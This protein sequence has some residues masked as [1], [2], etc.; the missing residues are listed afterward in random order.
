MDSQSLLRRL[1]TDIAE[2]DLIRPDERIVLGVSGGP[3]SMAMMHAL[4]E[5]NGQDKLHWSLHVAHLNHRIRGAE[6]EADAEFVA[7]E[8]KRLGLDRTIESE[9]I[10]ALSASSKRSIE[11]TARDRRYAFFNRVCIRTGS[12]VVAVAH[13]ADDN[14]ETVLHHIIRGSG[15]RGLAGIPASRVMAP[16]SETRIVRPM[17]RFRR[18]ELLAYLVQEDIGYRRDETN[19]SAVYTRN[20]LRNRVLPMLAEEFNPRIHEALLRL[21]EQARW[22]ADYLRESAARHFESVVLDDGEGQL[23]LSVESLR[24]KKPIIQAE[25]IRRAIRAF[26]AGTGGS[27]ESADR[28]IEFGHLRSVMS[29]VEDSGSGREVH[30][31][32]RLVA[33][34][35][36]GRLIIR[37]L[38]D[39]PSEAEFAD[40]TLKCPGESAVRGREMSIAI[41][42]TPFDEAEWREF[43]AGKSRMEE[44]IDADRVRPPIVA[45]GPHPGDRFRPL[46]SP[47]SKKLS[48]FF[49]DAKVSPEDRGAAVAVCDADGIVWLVG[50]RIDHRVRITSETRSVLRIAA[51]RRP[52]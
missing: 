16:G 32:G 47:G 1:R 22:S 30:L 46:G 5:L 23:D 34:R 11:E 27:A 24:K 48:D 14:A 3:D 44:W 33:A 7:A 4:V 9:D 18:E 52:G 8:A 51:T 39:R 25:L 12:H 6:A 35:R 49:I 21:A 37:R 19:D 42:A 41:V 36:Y 17:L 28:E 2:Q 43:K 13:Q 15:I 31:P 38:D 10:P 20:R 29:L 40:V 50:H 45:G 26:A